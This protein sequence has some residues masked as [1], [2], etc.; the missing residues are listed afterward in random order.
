MVIITEQ[1]NRCQLDNETVLYKIQYLSDITNCPEG[2]NEKL[3]Q[4]DSPFSGYVSEEPEKPRKK[5]LKKKR[6]VKTRIDSDEDSE[7]DEL[8]TKTKRNIVKK[9][10][11][12]RFE[13]SHSESDNESESDEQFTIPKGDISSNSDLNISESS[14][15]DNG[16][17]G[18]ENKKLFS[19][20]L[21]KS[22]KMIGKEQLWIREI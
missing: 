18:K 8:F 5:K 6:H 11:K 7:S 21:V 9:I 14:D 13:E 15:R 3:N 22:R 12:K 20:K 1:V 17:S 4:R 19:K 16:S 2:N 10:K